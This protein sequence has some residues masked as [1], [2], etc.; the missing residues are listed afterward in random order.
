LAALRA[1]LLTA[2]LAF[3]KY[4]YLTP[5]VAVVSSKLVP[6]TS[7]TL[8]F[9]AADAVLVA[10]RHTSYA[11]AP[12]AADQVTRTLSVYAPSLAFTFVGTF[13]CVK[14]RSAISRSARGAVHGDLVDPTATALNV[15]E[16][17]F[18]PT[19]AS[20]FSASRLSR[21]SDEPV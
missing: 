13:A 16:L 2:F 17:C 18:T 4:Q 7:A 1:L 14:M 20:S 12:V 15:T 9:V 11:C 5:G 10:P 6:T 19:A 21:S 3:T 8:N